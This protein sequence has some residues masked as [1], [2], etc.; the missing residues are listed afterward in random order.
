[1]QFEHNS[2][3]ELSHQFI[4]N[5]LKYDWWTSIW[6]NE[7]FAT[8]FGYLLVDTVYPE[9]NMKGFFNL[10]QIQRAY[11]TDALV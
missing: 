5:L 4:G 10:R 9:W 1:M 11:R 3:H 7:G 6:L 8:V 2:A